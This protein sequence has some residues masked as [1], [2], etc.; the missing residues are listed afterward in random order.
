MMMTDDHPAY[1]VDLSQFDGYLKDVFDVIGFVVSGDLTD[2]QQAAVAG[3][4]YLRG[5]ERYECRWTRHE[6]LA[7]LRS[8]PEILREF[9]EAFPFISL[10][11]LERACGNSPSEAKHGT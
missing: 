11:P 5:K 1:I 3:I 6:A 2:E 10:P 9:K 8:H 4:A 7:E